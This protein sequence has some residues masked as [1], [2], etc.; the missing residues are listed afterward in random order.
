MKSWWRS[1]GEEE[2][3]GGGEERRGE[4]RSGGVDKCLTP[5]PQH[6]GGNV[7]WVVWGRFGAGIVCYLYRMKGGVKLHFDNNFIA[8]SY[9]VESSFILYQDRD[10]MHPRSNLRNTY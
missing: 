3:R 1:G 7:I 9:T 8:M 2:S 6:R 10:P 4:E 5:S